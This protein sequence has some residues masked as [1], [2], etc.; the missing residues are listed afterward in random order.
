[1]LWRTMA[2]NYFEMRSIS[3][4]AGVTIRPFSSSVEIERQKLIRSSTTSAGAVCRKYAAW[5]KKSSSLFPKS[6]WSSNT[7]VMSQWCG[8]STVVTSNPWLCANSR[9][10]FEESRSFDWVLSVSQGNLWNV[11][12]VR[13]SVSNNET[14][15]K[16]RLKYWKYYMY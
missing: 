3:S 1:M 10:F 4:W 7:S 14:T 11:F 12:E 15:N 13:L 8:I 2:V 6:D 5:V 9:T 16:T